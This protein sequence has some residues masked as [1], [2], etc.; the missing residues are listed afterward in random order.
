MLQKLTELPPAHAYLAV[1]H[2]VDGCEVPLVL[3]RNPGKG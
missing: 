3:T 1:H 2:T